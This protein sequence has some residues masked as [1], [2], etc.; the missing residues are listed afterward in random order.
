M[1]MG[2]LNFETACSSFKKLQRTLSA[3]NHVLGV[4]YLDAATAAPKG[5]YAGRGQTM[6]VMSQIQYDLLSDPNNSELISVL[7]ENADV[8]D[9]QTR[10]EVEVFRKE[11]DRIHR[12][13][14]DAY[15][16]YNVLLNDAQSVWEEA[17][18]NND[19]AAFAPYL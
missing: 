3:Y 2:T 7:T 6:E 11:F 5:S 10:R 8:L 4:T 16:A 14:A 9:Q 1:T 13:P 15:V 12:I 17:K 18:K 19:F